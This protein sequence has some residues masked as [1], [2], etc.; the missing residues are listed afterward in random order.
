VQPPFRFDVLAECGPA[1]CGRIYTPHGPID[2]PAF[3][4]VG[5]RGAV[6]GV[7]PAQLAETGTQIVLANT[8]HLMQRPSAEVVAELGG[9]HRM[10]NWPG[11]ILTDSGGFQVFSLGALRT[12]DDDGVTFQSHIDGALIRLGPGEAIRVQRLLGADIIMCLDECPPLPATPALLRTAVE[13]TIAWAQRCRAAWLAEPVRPALYGIV[14]GGLDLALRAECLARLVEIGFE[15]YA[16]GGLSVGEPPADMHALLDEF[17]PRM[18]AAQPRYL[19]GVGTPLDLVHA[20]SAG[21]DQFDCVLPT[22]NGRKGYAFTSAGVLRLRN[23]EHRLSRAP[24]DPDCDCAT[25]QGFSRGYLRHLLLSD[26]VLGATLVC[27][28]NLRFYQRL[29]ARMRAALVAGRFPAWR[30]AFLASPAAG[31]V[32][33]N[34]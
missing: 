28:H 24:L 11:A 8:Y 9:L 4:P 32:K 25:C 33:E 18:P 6:K 16:L 13:R 19:M 29:M 31:Q 1:R 3:M 15:G 14:Q 30:E 2:T 17:A 10:M 20:V 22:R 27:L 5:T 21:I 12:I 7:S 26:E 34:E 23:A